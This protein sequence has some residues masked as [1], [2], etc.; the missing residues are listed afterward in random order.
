M[1]FDRVTHDPRKHQV[2]FC[3][4]PSRENGLLQAIVAVVMTGLPLLTTFAFKIGSIFVE[5]MTKGDDLHGAEETLRCEKG[6]GG[7]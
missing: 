5:Q 6:P 2:R 1:S 3:V 7:Y 4:K